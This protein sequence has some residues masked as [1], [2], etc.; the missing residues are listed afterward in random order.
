MKMKN[1]S[2]ANCLAGLAWF[3]R[4]YAARR[5]N[6][7]IAR[8]K[9]NKSERI[10]FRSGKATKGRVISVNQ[11]ITSDLA[12][13]SSVL[14]MLIGESFMQAGVCGMTVLAQTRLPLIPCRSGGNDCS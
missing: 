14:S 10:L 6:Q 4:R 3:S 12:I 5:S 7:Q 11:N 13:T 9:W 1:N 8:M 2:D